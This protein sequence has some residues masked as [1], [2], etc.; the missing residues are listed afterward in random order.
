MIL[1]VAL[2]VVVVASAA[3]PAR[4]DEWIVGVLDVR[5]EG[6]SEAAVV[7]FGEG[8]EEGVGSDDALTLAPQVRMKEQLASTAWST[9]CV[10]GPCLAEVHAGTGAQRVIT[11]GLTGAGES[12]RYTITMVDTR[13]GEVLGQVSDTCAACTVDDVAA[14]ATISTLRLLDEVDDPDDDGAAPV[15]APNRGEG[16]A[17]T[18]RRA[19]VLVLGLALLAAG[20]GGYFTH[21]DETDVG[22]PLLGLAGGFAASGTLM[23]GLSAKF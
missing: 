10:V 19:S 14:Q 13:S 1:R 22:Y 8:I 5:G 16:H 11:A 6:V 21:E 2:S 3:A 15:T 17:R 23:L 18:L 4:A 9:A 20:A 7:R 12:Y